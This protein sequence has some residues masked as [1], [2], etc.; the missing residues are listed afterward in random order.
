MIAPAPAPAHVLVIGASGFIGTA[1][2]G[3]LESGGH[4]VHAMKAPRLPAIDPSAARSFIQSDDLVDTLAP[5]LSGFDAVVNAA[6]NPDASEVD[7]RALTAAN[8]VLPGLLAAAISRS[9]G[10]PRLVHVSSAV[11]QGRARELDD[12]R[13]TDP[14]SAYARSK[15]LGEDLVLELAPDH[16]VVCRPPSVHAIDRRVTRLIG[17]IARSP[18]ATVAKPGSSPSPQALLVNVAAAIAFLATT[19]QRPPAIVIHPSEGLTTAGIMQVLGGRRP[20]EIPRPVA[21]A[22]VS[23][24]NAAG[25]LSPRVAAHSRRVEMLWFGQAQAASWLTEA[26]WTPPAGPGAWARIGAEL[27]ATGRQNHRVEGSPA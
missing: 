18:L 22:A 12:S 21:R 25:R 3:A 15:I 14:F 16:V 9:P 6:G 7:V 4:D 1:V 24:F 26:G 8:A 17:A 23:A 2:A 5:Q 19:P 10:S 20:R 13:T 27:V 11:V